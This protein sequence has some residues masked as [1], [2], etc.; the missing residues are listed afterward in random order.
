ML[1]LVLFAGFSILWYEI[2]HLHKEIKMTATRADLDAAI[3]AETTAVANAIADLQA[4]IAAGQ[5]TTPEDFSAEVAKL[6]AITTSATQ[7][8]PGPEPTDTQTT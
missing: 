4:K 6:Q 8:D 3:D 2:D 7:N 1:Y 5:V